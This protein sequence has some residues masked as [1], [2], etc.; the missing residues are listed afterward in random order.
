MKLKSY[1][2][3]IKL[4]PKFNN[5]NFSGDFPNPSKLKE[6]PHLHLRIIVEQAEYLIAGKTNP[7]EFSAFIGIETTKKDIDSLI[8]NLIHDIEQFSTQYPELKLL[9]NV[10]MFSQSQLPSYTLFTLARSKILPDTYKNYIDLLD[11]P[12][13]FDLFSIPFLVRLSIENK[14]KA[15]IGFKSSKSKLSDG[16]NKVSDQFPALKVINFLQT[17]EQIKSILPFDEIKKIYNWSCGFVHTGNKEYIWLSLKAVSSL[18]KLFNY[19]Y[20]R[21]YGRRINYLTPGV[22]VEELQSAI[23]S[24]PSFSK[25]NETKIIEESLSLTLSATEFDETSGFWDKRKGDFLKPQRITQRRRWCLR[26]SISQKVGKQRN[27]NL[28]SS[29]KRI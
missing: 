16:Q 8:N 26:K 7:K 28:K 24:S 27:Q 20:N 5:K 10:I 15:M 3:K 21:Y 2:E 11:Q 22:T 13:K 25:P 19:D 6:K 12:R 14:L 4:N 18:N 29:L 17:S 9:D 23:N 1:I